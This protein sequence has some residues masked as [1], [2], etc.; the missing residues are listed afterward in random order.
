MVHGK[1]YGLVSK[2]SVIREVF[3]YEKKRSAEIGEENV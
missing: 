2:R 1:M 3:E